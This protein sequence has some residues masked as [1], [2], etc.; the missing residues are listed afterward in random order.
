LVRRYHFQIFLSVIQTAAG[1]KK[2][3]ILKPNPP[4]FTFQRYTLMSGQPSIA[5]NIFKTFLSIM[6]LSASL[7]AEMKTDVEFA[8]VGDVS[9]TLDAFVPEGKGPFPTVIIVHG[10]GFTKGDKQ[11]FV[12]PLFDPLSK[13]GFTWFTINYRL[14]PQYT[15]PAQVEDVERAIEWVKA[16]AKEYKVDLKRIALTG[17][18]AGG[19]LVSMV[20]V[21]NKPKARVNAVIP[22]YGPHDLETRSREAKAI[23]APIEAFLGVKEFNEASLK[24]LHDASPI[25]Y[26]KPGLP[27]FL[28]IHGTKDAQVDYKQSEMMQ[29]KMKAVG[30]VCDL[31]YIK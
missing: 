13:A 17:E 6:L 4:R 23:T 20:G 22:F 27:P 5:M 15:Y 7:R 10:G 25:N 31:F 28:L 12:K 1:A 11:S 9:L 19:H 14:A 2:L 18:S 24:V 8:K 26:V 3:Q 30:N 21:Q 29:A 16:H